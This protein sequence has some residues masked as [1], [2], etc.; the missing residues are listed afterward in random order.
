MIK[1]KMLNFTHSDNR[2]SISKYYISAIFN[3]QGQQHVLVIL[4][5]SEREEQFKT[6]ENI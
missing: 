3:L 1:A 4:H 6:F 5:L 2:S